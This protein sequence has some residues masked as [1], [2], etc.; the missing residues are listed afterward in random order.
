LCA[1]RIVSFLFLQADRRHQA[2]IEKYLGTFHGERELLFRL[3][4]QSH[5]L[6]GHAERVVGFGIDLVGR[7]SRRHRCRQFCDN[8]TG[9]RE[10]FHFVV[11]VTNRVVHDRVLPRRHEFEGSGILKGRSGPI[12][13]SLE[14]L[15]EEFPR[16]RICRLRAD[17]R[18][19]P[20]F[21][22]RPLP[23]LCVGLKLLRDR[24]SRLA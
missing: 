7:S 5:V 4:D 17:D 16:V 21:G 1:C 23:R 10:F 9:R 2:G 15:T 3:L 22:L 24:K 19:E 14:H 13:F 20:L 6:I 18:A 8:R 11:E 12:A